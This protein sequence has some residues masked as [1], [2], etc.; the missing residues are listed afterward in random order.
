MPKCVKTKAIIPLADTGYIKSYSNFN[1]SFRVITFYDVCND[2]ELVT[3][4]DEGM[5]NIHHW[6]ILDSVDFKFS[7][8]TIIMEG[9][10]RWKIKRN[11]EGKALLNADSIVN[12]VG[13]TPISLNQVSQIVSQRKQLSFDYEDYEYISIDVSGGRR[14]FV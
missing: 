11:K 2:C 9:D 10:F 13:T 12:L 3:Y 1:S 4:L 6:D 14:S 5:V 7:H 8:D